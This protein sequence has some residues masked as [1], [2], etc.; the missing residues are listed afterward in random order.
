MSTSKVCCFFLARGFFSPRPVFLF[1][2]VPQG[3]EDVIK[4]LDNVTAATIKENPSFEKMEGDLH[5]SLSRTVY[6]K[7]FQIGRLV[8]LL[9][10]AL[11]IQDRFQVHFSHPETYVNDEKTRHF[12]GLSTVSQSNRLN[13]LKDQV[14]GVFAHIGLPKYYE[15]AKF[16]VSLGWQLAEFA[17]GTIQAL[18]ALARQIQLR[19]FAVDTVYLKTGNKIHRFSLR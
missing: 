6:L 17:P 5:V 4:L 9:S 2:L 16:H 12:L 19:S 18:S 1:L 8:Q 13:V 15:N 11:E 3:N 14:D 7:S 10:E